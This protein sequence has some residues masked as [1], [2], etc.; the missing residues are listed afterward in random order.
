VIHPRTGLGH[1]K[2]LAG[3]GSREVWSRHIRG[4]HRLVYEIKS[5]CIVF[6]ACY[7]HYQDH[8]LCR[9]LCSMLSHIYDFHTFHGKNAWN[10]HILRGEKLAPVTLS[11]GGKWH[12]LPFSLGLIPIFTMQ[13]FS[14]V[15]ALWINF[16]DIGNFRIIMHC[17]FRRKFLWTTKRD[18]QRQKYRTWLGAWGQR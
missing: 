3:Y 4:K 8:W 7:G 11:I 13:I 15:I 2:P 10:F 18:W 6:I 9:F 12:P 14:V 5:D 17:S 16:L 1:P